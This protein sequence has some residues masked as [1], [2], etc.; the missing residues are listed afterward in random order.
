MANVSTKV[1][2]TVISPFVSSSKTAFRD[3]E[4]TSSP[5]HRLDFFRRDPSSF[6]FL[7]PNWPLIRP[8]PRPCN[9]RPSATLSCPGCNLN[10]SCLPRACIC[11]W[12]KSR[13]SPPNQLWLEGFQRGSGQ[14]VVTWWDLI[15]AAM[16]L[17]CCS[18]GW[19]LGADF[20]CSSAMRP[21][22]A[23]AKGSLLTCSAHQ[24]AL[25]VEVTSFSKSSVEAYEGIA[26]KDSRAAANF[27]FAM[28][29][30]ALRMSFSRTFRESS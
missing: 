26:W 25:L 2:R 17:T 10:A 12:P 27:P 24:L 7:M 14:R 4:P 11:G 23:V 19:K 8:C 13:N 5:Q 1:S 3:A 22:I 30:F 16:S 29:L 6:F 21:S 28:L 9:A 20:A 18:A 15:R